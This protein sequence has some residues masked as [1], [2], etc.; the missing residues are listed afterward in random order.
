MKQ[1]FN[2][3][4][5]TCAS[6]VKTLRQRLE[7]I[8]LF[9]D[10]KI[11]I[12][13]PELTVYTVRQ[14]TSSEINQLLSETKFS[15]RD[16]KWYQ[17]FVYRCNKFLPL[18]IMTLITVIFAA[19]HSLYYGWSGYIFMQFLMAGYFLMFGTLKVVNWQKF[20][21]SYQAY[22]DLA[23]RSRVYAQL[24]PAIEITI[25]VLYYI[26]VMWWPLHV[27]V[28][29]LMTQKAYSTWHVLRSG[30]ILQCACL[31]GFFSIP[32]TRVTV[33]EDLFMAAMAVYMLLH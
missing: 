2:V 8:G 31:G 26:G 28:G 12:N 27:F 33:F 29:L 9:E 22:D 4:G 1:V 20:V 19:G 32:I 16:K 11:T 5:M 13:P 7:Q 17:G 3:T 10:L 30:S 23:K 24:Y 14:I 15:V 18:I 6:C 25:G 21:L